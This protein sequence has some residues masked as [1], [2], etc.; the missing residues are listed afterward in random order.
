MAA[1]TIRDF[2]NLKKEVTDM[3][4]KAYVKPE[5]TVHGDVEKITLNCVFQNNDTPNGNSTAFPPSGPCS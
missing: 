3:E 5:L 1:E 4:K 2:L